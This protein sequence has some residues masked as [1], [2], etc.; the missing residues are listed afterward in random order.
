MHAIIQL[1]PKY[2]QLFIKKDKQV[3]H[4]ALPT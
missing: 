1:R 4:T 3:H 2:V